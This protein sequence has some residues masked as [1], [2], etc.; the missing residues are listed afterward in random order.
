MREIIKKKRKELGLTQAMLARKCGVSLNTI[1]NLET[2]KCCRYDLLK[3]VFEIL[4]LELRAVDIRPV[5]NKKI[6]RENN[7]RVPLID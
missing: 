1:G 4:G 3:R 7:H 6:I 2:G 5:E